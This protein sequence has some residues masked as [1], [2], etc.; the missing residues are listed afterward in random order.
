MD[1]K[2]RLVTRTTQATRGAVHFFSP[3]TMAWFHS[4]LLDV[5]WTDTDTAWFIVSD[6]PFRSLPRLYSVHVAQFTPLPDGE[7]VTITRP[8]EKVPT[9]RRA[10]TILHRATGKAA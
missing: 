7:L 1:D 3:D 6:R 5:T 2:N 8:A 4:R 10:R 9:L